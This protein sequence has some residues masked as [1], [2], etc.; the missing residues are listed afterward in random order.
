MKPEKNKMKKEVIVTVTGL[1]YMGSG[2]E[3]SDYIDVITPGTYY[4]KNE[5]HYLFYEEMM[6]GYDEP[7]RNMISIEPDRVLLKKSGIVATYMEFLP[8]TRTQTWYSTPFGKM[9]MDIYTQRIRIRE[10]EEELAVDIR[11]HLGLMGDERNHCF[12]KVL[13]QPREGVGS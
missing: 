10:S 8:K 1:L 13:V 2:E 3:E 4:E 9:D 5:V 6:E 12:V 7:V 11:Y